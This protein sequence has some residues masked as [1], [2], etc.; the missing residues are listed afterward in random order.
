[1]PWA[2]SGQIKKPSR[3]RVG[4]SRIRKERRLPH[5]PVSGTQPRVGTAGRATATIS[6]WNFS[7]SLGPSWVL[8]VCYCRYPRAKL[9]F[10]N[11]AAQV[12]RVRTASVRATGRARLT[13]GDA[14]LRVSRNGADAV[15]PLHASF[16][17]F[18]CPQDRTRPPPDQIKRP[19]ETWR[20]VLGRCQD[21]AAIDSCRIPGGV[22]VSA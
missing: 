10:N 19:L 8:P 12:I 9:S 22:P 21:R 1:M 20:R 6:A 11:E 2:R 13:M 3:F 7:S 14:P 18:I 17:S 16:A 5:G 15:S 4:S